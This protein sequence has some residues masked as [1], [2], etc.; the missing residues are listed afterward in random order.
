MWCSIQC[1][2]HHIYHFLVCEWKINA[3]IKAKIIAAAIPPAVAVKPPVNIPR[4]PCDFTAEIAP[5]A[6]DA[7]KPMIGTFMPA[8]AKSEM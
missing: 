1:I 7:P 2:L 8:P 6:S 3:K 4:R 5:F